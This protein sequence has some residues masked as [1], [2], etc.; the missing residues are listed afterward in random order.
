MY[1]VRLTRLV[2]LNDDINVSIL[3][4]KFLHEVQKKNKI[5]IH[6]IYLIYVIILSKPT[7]FF[8]ASKICIIGAIMRMASSLI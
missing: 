5:K 2:K 3:K 6:D 8:S 4:F 7:S 1:K